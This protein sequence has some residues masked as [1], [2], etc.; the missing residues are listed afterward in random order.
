M[1]DHSKI[2]EWQRN[3]PD[4]VKEYAKK[5][6]NK[7]KN[8]PIRSA[9]HRKKH[10]EYAK[11][12]RELN[13]DKIKEQKKKCVQKSGVSHKR[14]WMS[15]IIK[16]DGAI[17]RKCGA[18]SNLTLQHKIPRCIGGKY[19]YDNLEILCLKCNI[20]DYHNLVNTAL[21]EYF[22]LIQ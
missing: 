20:S 21:K 22:K 15:K 18:T 7:R 13:K 17:C 12:W 10:K 8:D 9:E 11:K 6:R 2:K 1:N 4:K 16:R 5:C 3:N 14:S 19:S